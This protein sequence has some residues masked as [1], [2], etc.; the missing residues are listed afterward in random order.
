MKKTLILT[1]VL[2]MVA[3]TAW[4]QRGR[5]GK[6]RPDAPMP[7]GQQQG[8]FDQGPGMAGHEGMGGL[9]ML[10]DELGLNDTQ[11]EKIKALTLENR[12]EMVDLQAAVKKSGL[13]VKA[14]MQG[15]APETEVI[16]AIERASQAKMEVAKAKYLHHQAMKDILTEEQQDKMM[17]LHQKRGTMAG[18][19]KFDGKQCCPKCCQGPCDMHDKGADKGG[20]GQF[21]DRRYGR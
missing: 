13:K 8:W 21:R 19:P 6:G 2:A 16:R 20:Q 4:S 10:A 5:T 9:L 18:G 3:S 15:D 11:R 1:L 12:M 17:K 7:A 14:L